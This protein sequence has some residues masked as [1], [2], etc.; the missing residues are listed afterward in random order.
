MNALYDRHETPEQI[1]FEFHLMPLAN[2][3]FLCMVTTSLLPRGTGTSKILRLCG[4]L[5]ILWVARLLPAW[6]ELEKAM[7]A[8]PV[9]ISGSKLSFTHPLKIVISKKS[10]S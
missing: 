8:G 1:E 9:T 7:A 4:I 6:F 2:A 5:L 3:L 10:I